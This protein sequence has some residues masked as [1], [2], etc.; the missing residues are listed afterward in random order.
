MKN[1]QG[2]SEPSQTNVSH[3]APIGSFLVR[4]KWILLSFTAAGL[5]AGLIVLFAV[6]PTYH[7]EARLLVRYITDSYSMGDVGQ[8]SQLTKSTTPSHDSMTSELEILTS[9]DVAREAAESVGVSK[10]IGTNEPSP[11]ASEAAAYIVRN[12]QVEIPPQSS[13]FKIS[14]AH[15]DPEVTQRALDELINSYLRCHLKIHREVGIHNDFLT[16]QRDRFKGEVATADSQIDS[17]RLRAGGLSL[18]RMQRAFEDE[19]AAIQK[20]LLQCEVDLALNPSREPRLQAL[21]ESTNRPP[22]QVQGKQTPKA[23]QIADL[24]VKTN[25]LHTQLQK[26]LSD[27]AKC[28]ELRQQVDEWERRK[29][30]AETNLWKYVSALESAQ[31]ADILGPGTISSIV[32]VQAPTPPVS[33]RAP[34]ICAVGGT[35]LGGIILGFGCAAIV[36]VR[37]RRPRSAPPPEMSPDQPVH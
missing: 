27:L 26:L 12:L 32:R 1:N 24:T 17:L 19:A 22:D 35:W 10:I 30:L 2:M 14:F 7:S 3:R 25:V 18:D 36:D 37:K 29:Q 6:R 8:D 5:I 23:L 20:D 21:Q 34:V 9:F 16:K 28:R 11:T 13:V 31:I 15:F 33:D 4:R